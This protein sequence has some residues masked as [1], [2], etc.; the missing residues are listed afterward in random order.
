MKV[1]NIILNK[2]PIFQNPFLEIKIEK[3]SAKPISLSVEYNL[4]IFSFSKLKLT[5]V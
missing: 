5:K 1:L 2:K 4:Y 3:V